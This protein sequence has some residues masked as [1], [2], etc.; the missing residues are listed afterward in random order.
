MLYIIHICW[1]LLWLNAC[2]NC[3]LTKKLRVCI[4]HVKNQKWAGVYLIIKIDT[5]THI[6]SICLQ[7]LYRHFIYRTSGLLCLLKRPELQH[8]CS[9]KN[10]PYFVIACTKC[11]WYK[12]FN[13]SGCNKSVR[14]CPPETPHIV[15]FLI[16]FRWLLESF[17]V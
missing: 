3:K 14:I 4:Q 5:H 11:A 10:K 8:T 13:Q 2:L 17:S 12:S 15:R 7:D 1:Q 9:S 6:F 16:Y